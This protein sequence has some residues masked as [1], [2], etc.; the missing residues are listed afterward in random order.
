MP[1]F[2]ILMELMMME[3]VVTTGAIS[4]VVTTIDIDIAIAIIS[5]IV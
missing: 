4:S 2:R 3:A 5:N 1:P